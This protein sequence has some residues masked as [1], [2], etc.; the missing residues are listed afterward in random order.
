MAL[1]NPDLTGIKGLE[2]INPGVYPAKIT[3]ADP[4]VSKAGNPIVKAEFDVTVD[5]D[6][7]HRFASIPTSGAGA[8]MFE[9]LLRATHFDDVADK[10]KAGEP[11]SFDTDSLIGQEINLQIESDM[12]NGAVTDKIKG[13]LKH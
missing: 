4:G 12:Y 9:Q 13:Y 2:A 10:L 5:N 11:T 7:R 6:S 8:F 1:I 3:K